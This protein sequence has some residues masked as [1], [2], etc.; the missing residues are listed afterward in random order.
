MEA[1]MLLIQ[2]L[3]LPTNVSSIGGLLAYSNQAV[4]NTLGVGLL[5]GLFAIVLIGGML[6][7][8][9]AEESLTAASVLCLLLSLLMML[10]TPPIVSSLVPGVFAGLAMLGIV[11]M[12]MRGGSSV[13]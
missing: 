6:K 11:L 10:M 1:I 13:Y 4:N 3:S 9:D 5:F 2:N 8:G 7:G 12:L